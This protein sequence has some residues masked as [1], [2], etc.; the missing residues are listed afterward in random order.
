M[1]LLFLSLNAAGKTVY[2]YSSFHEPATEGLRLLY[3][4][5][6]K[7]WTDFDTTF[8]KPEIG[9]QKVM[10]DP[11]IVRGPDKVYRLVWTSSWKGDL[12]FG[13]ASS[14]DLI[15]WSKQQFLPVMTYDT[16]TVNVWAPEIFYDQA[17][18]QYII[19]WASTVPFKFPK[20]IEDEY[21]NHRLY[22]TATK[23]FKTFT[24]TALFYDPGYSVIDAMIVCRGKSDYVLV[25]K[26]NTRSE[27]DIKVA[28]GETA[29]GPWVNA[30]KALTPNFTEGPSATK[31]GNEWLIYYDAYKEGRYPA[32]RTSDFKTFQE[33]IDVDV[34]KG[35]KHGTVFRSDRHTWRKIMKSIKR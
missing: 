25:F 21:N 15:H 28:F 12:G 33:A 34:P 2:M 35:H 22:Y 23:D 16:S 11:S 8:I 1:L 9:E 27:R 18:K 24:K 26:D 13:Y 32:I 3:S 6:G 31:V 29:L 10:R 19:V 20:G 17:T 4:F 7:R 14:K 5:D 30:S